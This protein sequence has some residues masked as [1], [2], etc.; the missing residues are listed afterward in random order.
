METFNGQCACGATKIQF[1]LPK[2][3]DIPK[4]AFCHCLFCK[5]STG[6]CFTRNIVVP[7]SS[8]TFPSE[9]PKVYYH[10]LSKPIGDGVPGLKW[11]FCSTCGVQLFSE[12]AVLPGQ[13]VVRVGVLDRQDEFRE[14]R[15]QLFCKRANEWVKDAF[16]S[17]QGKFDEFPSKPSAEA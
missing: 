5:R 10:Q 16:E 17:E 9:T 6:A 12:S 4:Q 7:R 15:M 13:A 1:Q 11:H 3:D 14:V 8:I 2:A